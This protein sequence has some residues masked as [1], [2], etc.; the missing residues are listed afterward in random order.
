MNH[1]SVLLSA[2]F[3]CILTI[4]LHACCINLL[5]Q[6]VTIK[7]HTT[8]QNLSLMCKVHEHLT[9]NDAVRTSKLVYR[10][11]N[12]NKKNDFSLS[13][14]IFTHIQYMYCAFCIV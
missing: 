8:Q 10:E 6:K 1:I 2:P 4:L 9:R 13:E 3:L 14:S 12:L 7:H 5:N 11:S